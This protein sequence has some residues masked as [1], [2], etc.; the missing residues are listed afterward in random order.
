[1]LCAPKKNLYFCT[2]T[3][4]PNLLGQP[5]IAYFSYVKLIIDFL[6]LD[7]SLL[8]II[9]FFTSVDYTMTLT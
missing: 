7:G 3:R 4:G 2:N 8:Q 1:V 9:S 6:I 5:D